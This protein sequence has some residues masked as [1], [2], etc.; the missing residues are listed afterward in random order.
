[1]STSTPEGAAGTS[2]T[3]EA[4]GGAG[5]DASSAPGASPGGSGDG[6]AAAIVAAAAAAAAATLPASSPLTAGEVTDQLLTVDVT[7][8]GVLAS[9]TGAAHGEILL[10]VGSDLAQAL[11][12]SA[13]GELDLAT[14][15][16]GVLEAIAGCFG[17]AVVGEAQVVEAENVIMQWAARGGA[18]AA[19]L[20]DGGSGHAAIAITLTDAPEEGEF[21][22][23]AG[24]LAA[25]DPDGHLRATDGEV[26]GSGGGLHLLHGVE[27]DVTA[28]LGRTRLAVREL[29]SL[30]PGA[31]VELDRAAGDPADLLVNGRPIARG[32]VVVIDE[33]FGLRITEILNGSDAE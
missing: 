5:V 9:F 23:A 15:V 24:V 32:E 18:L 13:V 3:A 29:L 2:D 6:T 11:A 28:E 26:A 4:A 22:A 17:P 25:A 31:I 8:Q 19:P 1:M 33:N 20:L 21:P 7:G 30:T 14:A 16:R 27:M 12:G 10:V